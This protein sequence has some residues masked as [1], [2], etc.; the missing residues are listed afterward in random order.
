MGNGHSLLMLAV[1]D[2]SVKI[3]MGNDICSPATAHFVLV[4]DCDP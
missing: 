2:T 4:S 1:L 3:T